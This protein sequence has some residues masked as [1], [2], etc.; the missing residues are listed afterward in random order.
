MKEKGEWRALVIGF[1][2]SIAGAYGVI[3][4][5]QFVLMRL[6]LGLRMTSAILTYWLIAAVP[7]I[8]AAVQKM[9]LSDYGFSKNKL[10]MQ[11]LLGLAVGAAMSLMFTLIPHLLG[12]GE[13]FSSGKRYQYLWQF[14]YELFYCV[15]AVGAVEEFVFRGFIY[16]RIKNIGKNEMTAVIGSSVLFGLFHIFGG[17]ILQMLMTAVL[18]A[19]WCV[20]RLKIKNCTILS[21]I[22]AHGFYDWLIVGWTAVLQG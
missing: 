16:E 18:G 17:N 1:L 3:L 14:V 6:P 5:N 8:V 9:R 21:L 4:F 22:I 11:I 10:G 2:G 15:L 20:C 12:F 19:F 13:Y 7:I